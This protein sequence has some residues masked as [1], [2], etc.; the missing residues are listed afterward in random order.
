MNK[1]TEMF[2]T[3]TLELTNL[4]EGYFESNNYPIN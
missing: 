4:F 2:I 3:H 1:K